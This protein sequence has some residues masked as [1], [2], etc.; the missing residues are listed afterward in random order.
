MFPH[1][2]GDAVAGKAAFRLETFGNENFWTDVVKLPQG[3]VAAQFTPKQALMA[4][5]HINVDQLDNATKATIAAEVQ[6]DLSPANAPLLNDPATTVKLINA[7]AARKFKW[8]FWR[9]WSWRALDGA[10][11]GPVGSMTRA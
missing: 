2:R 5:Y 4:G 6:T 10:L 11:V 3:I 8:G 9:R 1:E 7:N